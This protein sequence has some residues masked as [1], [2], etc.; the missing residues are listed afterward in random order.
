MISIRQNRRQLCQSCAWPIESPAERGTDALGARI[1][2]Y[3]VYCFHKGALT[4]P[5]LSREEMIERVA[6]HLMKHDQLPHMQAREAAETLVSSLA[7]W[8]RPV[9][10]AA[11]ALA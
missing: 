3:C 2:D 4:E 10:A 9:S 8:K 1:D 7:R 6:D 5:D 11:Q